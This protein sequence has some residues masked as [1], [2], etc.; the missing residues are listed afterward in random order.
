MV[1]IKAAVTGRDSICMGISRAI[2]PFIKKIMAYISLICYNKAGFF[3]GKEAGSN[4][5]KR[6]KCDE[7]CAVD[8]NG[9]GIK[10]DEPDAGY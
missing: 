10:P 1:G 5:I 8:K 6:R 9:A 3:D 2:P 7:G 4:A